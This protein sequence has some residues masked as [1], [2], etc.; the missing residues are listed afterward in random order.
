MPDF[1]IYIA[2]TLLGS[3]ITLI[4]Q[5][6]KVTKRTEVSTE[7]QRQGTPDKSSISQQ[8][9]KLI[10]KRVT[11]GIL[12][13]PSAEEINETESEK[14]YNSVVGNTIKKLFRKANVKL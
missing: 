11:P 8:L 2:F 12:F 10:H 7:S 4:S 5:R 1:L 14:E 9:K 3:L 6:Y 13:A